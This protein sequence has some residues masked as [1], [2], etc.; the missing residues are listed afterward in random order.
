MTLNVI[1][2]TK[3]VNVLHS[4]KLKKAVDKMEIKEIIVRSLRRVRRDYKLTHSDFAS[5]L[6]INRTTLYLYESGKRLFPT[7][8]IYKLWKEIG[9][10][11][12]ELMDDEYGI[13]EEKEEV[14]G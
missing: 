14:K 9:V 3:R 8:L 7:E 4:K 11:P 2:Y 5:R 6:G 10:S 12:S 13:D 1:N